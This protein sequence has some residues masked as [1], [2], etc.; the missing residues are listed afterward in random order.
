[1]N[2]DLEG[3]GAGF[4]KACAARYTHYALNAVYQCRPLQHEFEQLIAQGLVLKL[5]RNA[6]T[7]QMDHRSFRRVQIVARLAIRIF[8]DVNG[9]NPLGID[10]PGNA[11]IHFEHAVSGGISFDPASNYLRSLS[12]WVLANTVPR[13]NL[14]RAD[15]PVGHDE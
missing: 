14:A 4:P 6:Q 8:E 5:R 2:V 1:M 13:D 7:K 3:C 10:H 11:A 15:P 12:E 9:W